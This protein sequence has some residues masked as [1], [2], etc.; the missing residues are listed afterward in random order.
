MHCAKRD[1]DILLLQHGELSLWQRFWVSRHLATCPHCQEKQA[2]FARTA[3]LLAGAIRQDG[4]LPAFA[5]RGAMASPASLPAL[6]PVFAVAATTAALIAVGVYA[7][8]ATAAGAGNT[9]R[10]GFSSAPQ[11]NAKDASGNA[12]I[13]PF[14]TPDTHDD[15]A[16]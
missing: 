8:T 15:C 6:R 11:K 2:E 14:S 16:R 3:R 7:Y 4:G 9:V 1:Q 5:F 13:F 12:T 10:A